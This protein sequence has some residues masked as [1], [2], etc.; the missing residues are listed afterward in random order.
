MTK[1]SAGARLR[2]RRRTPAARRCRR[3]GW[4]PRCPSDPSTVPSP[5]SPSSGSSASASAIVDGRSSFGSTS[6]GART[7]RTPVVRL[8]LVAAAHEDGRAGRPDLLAVA[9]I[10]ERQRPREV[11]RG[12]EIHG[13]PARPAAPAR[14]PTAWR[15][16]RRP[17]P[18]RRRARR[19]SGRGRL[20]HP[21]RP[22]RGRRAAVAPRIRRTSSSYL[23][24][25]P[26]VSSTSSGVSSRAPSDRSA[27]AQSSV[28]AIAGHLGQVGLAQAMDEADDLARPAARA[29]RARGRGR[30]RS[31]FCAV[32]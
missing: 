7:G 23:R 30:S 16:D 32:G 26:R 1:P 25:T 19:R 24:T 5:G 29:P 6:G 31:S 2:R 20:S 27:A 28:S 17:R 11:D 8:E 21:P 4:P 18:D 22:P 15:S 13:Q 3:A 10:D 9:D 12:P 14:T